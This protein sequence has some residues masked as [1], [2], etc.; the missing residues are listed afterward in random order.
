MISR[1]RLNFDF[2]NVVNHA[3]YA[4]LLEATYDQYER[5]LFQLS[6]NKIDKLIIFNGRMDF[7]AASIAA[8]KQL[9]IE[10]FTVERSWL[11]YGLNVTFNGSPLDCRI[12]E[13][14]LAV[15]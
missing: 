11:G 7:T 13:A 5:I 9:G 6:E 1:L 2:E 12:I 15:P 3:N 14:L 4:E 10:F 8:A